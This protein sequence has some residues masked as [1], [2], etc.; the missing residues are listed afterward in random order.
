M[1]AR[2]FLGCF[3]SAVRTPCSKPLLQSDKPCVLRGEVSCREVCACVN[4]GEHLE[5]RT[6]DKAEFIKGLGSQH[7][8]LD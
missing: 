1:R 3:Y 6:K 5:L 4:L 8:A 2:V 7:P